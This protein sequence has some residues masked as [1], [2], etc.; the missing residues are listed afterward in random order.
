VVPTSSPKQRRLLFVAR[1]TVLALI[2][3]VVAHLGLGV[4]AMGG[5]A[6]LVWPPT[7]VALAALVVF[8]VGLWPGVAV[9]ALVANLSAGAPAGV[10]AG[11]SVGNTLEAVLG[12]TVVARTVGFE[13]GL[14]TLRSVASLVLASLGSTLVSATVGVGSMLVGHVIGEDLLAS[15][16]LSWWLGDLIGALIVAPLLLNLSVPGGDWLRGKELEAAALALL[17]ATTVTL[18]FGHG[19]QAFATPLRRPFVV[20]PYLIW[21]AVRFG[22]R[23]ATLATFGASAGAV[24]A[25]ALNRDG[26]S[27]AALHDRLLELQCFMAVAAV[28]FLMLGAAIAERRRLFELERAAHA[29]ARRA[30][31]V[32]DDFLAIASHELRTP[33]TPLQLQ[34]DGLLRVFD[35]DARLRDRLER[36]SRQTARLARLTEELLDVSRIASGR[37][38]LRIERFDLAALVADLLD[39]QR[40]S[41]M[42]AGSQISLEPGLPAWVRWDKVRAAQAVSGLVANAIRYGRGKPIEVTLSATDDVVEVSV[43]DQ[44]VGIELSA[45]SKIF[46]RFER[47]AAARAY[48]GLGLGLYVV[49]EIARAHGG[50]VSVTSE[51]GAGSVFKLRVPREPGVDPT[52]NRVSEGPAASGH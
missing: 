23:G 22:P 1:V 24:A 31:R 35:G 50:D 17:L 46:E 20:M 18:V 25:T 15:T 43:K 16:W 26:L 42:K 47:A 7:G 10:A 5:L 14:G 33:L 39:Q 2:Y 37:L 3:A 9:G 45:Q 49:R 11:I 13:R 29:E 21:A 34:L 12:A 51:P 40:E 48:G 36:A 19:A 41:A 44:G 4:E 52:P 27:P 6:T 28:T 32:R 30:V 38:E 8:G